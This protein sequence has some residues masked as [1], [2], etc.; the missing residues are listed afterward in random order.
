[1]A[2][3]SLSDAY[4]AS[5]TYAKNQVDEFG[6][7]AAS[8]AE[9]LASNLAQT[10]E[11]ILNIS[12]GD[13]LNDIT[14]AVGD[15]AGRFLQEKL[16][17]LQ[18]SLTTKT[19]VEIRAFVG[20]VAPYVKSPVEAAA[21]LAGKIDNLVEYYFSPNGYLKDLGEDFLSFAMNDPS[22][23]TTL[24][25]LTVVQAF[26][27][28][29]NTV[30]DSIDTLKSLFSI[31]E[32]ILPI[33]EVTSDLFA[34]IRIQNAAAGTEA[35]LKAQ[36]EVQRLSQQLTTLLLGSFRKWVFSLRVEVPNLLLGAIQT[37]SVRDAMTLNN[38]IT[39][40]WFGA[41]FDEDFY[42]QTVY[43]YT[44]EE[45]WNKTIRD[46]LGSAE[47]MV[48]NWESFNFTDING[49]PITRG[50][51]LKS[52]VMTTFT[53]KFLKQAVVTAR[54]EARIRQF[55]STDWVTYSSNN[56]RV[57]GDVGKGE[58]ELLSF[59]DYLRKYNTYDTSPFISTGSIRTLSGQIL[60]RY[61]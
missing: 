39:N 33:I 4:N 19:S 26:A 43:S 15:A 25:S 31:V 10:G 47:N 27:S 28:S 60:E 42:D 7:I 17:A 30:A 8:G 21:A 38:D 55:S 61:N 53:Q 40:G 13:D 9:R 6:N 36:K 52:K 51:F 57:A 35:Q 20:E 48:N 32:P 37:L 58:D 46:T 41:I 54:K 14:G 34:A 59:K 5:T 2:N 11:D 49:N 22:I 1:M 16:K 23:Q 12:I 18:D 3:Q 29:L 24:S 44:W 56:R 45:S 50:E